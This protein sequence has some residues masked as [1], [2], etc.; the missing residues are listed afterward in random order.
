VENQACILS[1]RA[2]QL[3]HFILLYYILNEWHQKQE[4]NKALI[5]FFVII[6]AILI[7]ADIYLQGPEYF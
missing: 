4:K 2:A 7:S 5:F 6:S 1:I 3:G